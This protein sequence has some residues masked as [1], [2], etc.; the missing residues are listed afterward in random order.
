M[1]RRNPQTHRTLSDLH[2]LHLHDT[3]PIEAE[4]TDENGY[5]REPVTGVW[6]SESGSVVLTVGAE[7]IVPDH[8]GT[9]RTD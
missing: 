4:W 9:E 5:H 7:Q 3:T 6:E 8:A 2:N 1:P